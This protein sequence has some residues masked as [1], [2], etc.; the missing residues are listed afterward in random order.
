[1]FFS[2]RLMEMLIFMP[3]AVSVVPGQPEDRYGVSLW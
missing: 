1:M 3:D 2:K